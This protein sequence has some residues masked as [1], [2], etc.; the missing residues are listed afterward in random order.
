MFD[1]PE[2]PR[3]R[4]LLEEQAMAIGE[5]VAAYDVDDDMVWQLFQELDR[6]ARR[7]LDSTRLVDGGSQVGLRRPGDPHPAVRECLRRLREL[8]HD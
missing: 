2:V 5:V 3:I 1:I 6:V 4:G 8:P 7:Y